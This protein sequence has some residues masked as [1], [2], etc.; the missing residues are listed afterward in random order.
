MNMQA[1]KYVASAAVGAVLALGTV[2]TQVPVAVGM[3]A[4]WYCNMVPVEDQDKFRDG[5]NEAIAP[6]AIDL[7]CGG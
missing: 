7:K 3:A 4:S 6:H 1:V 5:I 2:W